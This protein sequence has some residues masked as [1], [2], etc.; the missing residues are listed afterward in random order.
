MADYGD[1]HH[2]HPDAPAGGGG[3]G[4]FRTSH[5]RQPM[6]HDPHGGSAMRRSHPPL[7]QLHRRAHGPYVR[8]LQRLLN[9][10]VVPS[11]ELIV[12]G[13]FGPCT[14]AA[15]RAFQ[16]GRRI[17]VDGIV[18]KV[19]WAHL[20]GGRRVALPR[21]PHKGLPKAMTGSRQVS[22][23][24]GSR[25]ELEL[26]PIP[27]S[28]G[29]PFTFEVEDD[30]IWEWPLD[31]KLRAVVDRLW[32]PGL[33]SDQAL[34]DLRAMI[35]PKSLVTMLVFIVLFSMLSGG[36]A[37]VL[38][39]VAFGATVGM[40][41]AFALQTTAQ[42]VSERDLDEAARELAHAINQVGVQVVLFGLSRAGRGLRL[43]LG[44][45]KEPSPTEPSPPPTDYSTI[46][47]R[48]HPEPDSA[49]ARPAEPPPTPRVKTPARNIV[50]PRLRF[51]RQLTRTKLLE[52]IRRITGDQE[53]VLWEQ[54][55]P[56]DWYDDVEAH[57][58]V[59]EQLGLR[60]GEVFA[61]HIRSECP[62]GMHS[63]TAIGLVDEIDPPLGDPFRP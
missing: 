21:V 14:L 63:Q 60:E 32:K 49:P 57:G 61:Y 35:E 40:D 47:Y 19:T 6:G 26:V 38:G 7:P 54:M 30:P 39:I 4:H 43:R 42:A 51:L 46:D 44:K 29:A 62:M 18:G 22:P 8:R 59:A 53:L 25:E 31:L 20:L 13:V 45:A 1:N 9:V 23:P 27:T 34:K 3:P 2:I 24:V 48:T 52:E 41:F 15:V 36:T 5:F 10:R 11:P 50:T 58:Q 33:L 56:G 37:L 28:G 55:E 17:K 16:R 12:D